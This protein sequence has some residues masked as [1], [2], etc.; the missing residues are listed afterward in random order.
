M[1]LVSSR[2]KKYLLIKEYP[3][4]I[5]PLIFAN[6]I[7]NAIANVERNSS[8]RRSIK[9]NINKLENIIS[10]SNFN[11]LV[12]YID[13]GKKSHYYNNT[14]DVICYYHYSEYALSCL[15]WDQK[16]EVYFNLMGIILASQTA[17]PDFKI[18]TIKHMI[19]ID[20]DI[21]HKSCIA[22][23]NPKNLK[24]VPST[25]YSGMYSTYMPPVIF[26]VHLSLPIEIIQEL[27]ID[28]I[29]IM[30]T[31]VNA[32]VEFY[33]VAKKNNKYD[34]MVVLMPVIAN[35]LSRI[36]ECDFKL[37]NVPYK[38]FEAGFNNFQNYIKYVLDDSD[39]IS[40]IE[41]MCDISEKINAIKLVKIAED[42]ATT[43]LKTTISV[44]ELKNAECVVCFSATDNCRVGITS[45]GHY[46]CSTCY[47]SV[48]ESFKKCPV[49][50]KPLTNE[51]YDMTYM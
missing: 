25:Y 44:E 36:K 43:S 19:S 15:N 37:I 16:S 18:N 7:G 28:N 34:D 29:N 13:T 6:E 12:E 27:I 40:I 35:C 2:N 24:V 45:C 14:N 48:F 8:S 49:C 3:Y 4:S 30:F 21:I 22:F 17:T 38:I 39:Y 9:N 41:Y 32:I 23:V 1:G 50:Q 47:P 11:Q 31:A 42:I 5:R 51:S 46:I 20:P 26:A 33:N 10:T